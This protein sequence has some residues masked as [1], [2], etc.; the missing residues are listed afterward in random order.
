MKDEYK[1]KPYLG[2]RFSFALSTSKP[3]T[4]YHDP[5]YGRPVTA[6]YI[7]EKAFFNNN[8]YGIFF[9]NKEGRDY[10]L[11][12][13]VYVWVCEKG[14][15]REEVEETAQVIMDLLRAAGEAE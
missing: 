3:N 10:I 7:N 5:G 2:E 6:Y 1:T 13:W 11:G 12:Q 15:T 9:A 8:A 14:Q 4:L